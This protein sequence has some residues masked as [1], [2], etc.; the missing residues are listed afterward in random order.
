LAVGLAQIAAI[1]I[2]IFATFTNLAGF[3]DAFLGPDV[4]DWLVRLVGNV[5]FAI[6]FG[7]LVGEG[8]RWLLVRADESAIR[9]AS[10]IAGILGFVFP[11]ISAGTLY[12]LHGAAPDVAETIVASDVNRLVA[13]VAMYALVAGLAALGIAALVRPEG[14]RP[15]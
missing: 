9:I 15:A 6:I 5:A 2:G 14:R 3:I 8:V 11:V 12:L 4:A 1:L 13:V 10:V 7:Y